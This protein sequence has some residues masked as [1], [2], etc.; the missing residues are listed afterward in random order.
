MTKKRLFCSFD[1]D[2][3]RFLKEALIEQSRNPDSPFE[4]ADHSL[5]EAA[6]EKDWEAKAEAAIKRSDVV[7]VL[8]GT[9][10]HSASGVLK[11]VAMARRNETPIF[12]LQP[13]EKSPKRV[14]D[15]GR[16]HDWTW[17]NLKNLLS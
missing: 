3:D 8:L 7:A 6:P 15:G 17:P 5:K 4:V 13:Q 14:D 11:E 1:F 2:N 10:T 12:Q 16:V 9:H